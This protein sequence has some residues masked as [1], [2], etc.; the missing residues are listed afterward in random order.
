MY[1]IIRISEYL[2]SNYEY[3]AISGA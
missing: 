1:L 3:F 2:L